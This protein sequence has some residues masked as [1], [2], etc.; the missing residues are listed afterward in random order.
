MST[1]LS[2][3][4]LLYEEIVMLQDIMIMLND[5][6]FTNDLDPAEREI[7]EDLYDKVINS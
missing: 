3:S 7:F 4:N 6:N 1:T 2:I 5:A